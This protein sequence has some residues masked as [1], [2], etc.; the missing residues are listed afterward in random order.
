LDFLLIGAQERWNFPEF[1]SRREGLRA[2]V[3]FAWMPTYLVEM[4]IMVTVTLIGK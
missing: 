1:Y 2:G 4:T 3:D